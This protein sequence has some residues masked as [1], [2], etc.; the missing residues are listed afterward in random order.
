MVLHNIPDIYSLKSP[1]TTV[2]NLTH[3][4]GK[5]VSTKSV[6]ERCLAKQF[7]KV[8]SRGKSY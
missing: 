7:L 5:V 1:Y 8:A 6:F 2:G 4:A 3:I